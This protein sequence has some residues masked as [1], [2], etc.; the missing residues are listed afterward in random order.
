M[1]SFPQR[2][3]CQLRLAWLLS[4]VLLP[5]FPDAA[6]A[7]SSDLKQRFVTVSL[8]RAE[9]PYMTHGSRKRHMFACAQLLMLQHRTCRCAA[10]YLVQLQQLSRTGTVIAGGLCY[11]TIY[12]GC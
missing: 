1:C 7:G 10:H 6:C 4:L 9:G 8:G 5:N 2:L 12:L 3:L 11:P